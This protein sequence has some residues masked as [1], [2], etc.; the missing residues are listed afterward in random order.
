MYTHQ[1]N[2]A[3]PG[4]YLKTQSQKLVLSFLSFEIQKVISQVLIV[5]LLLLL[6]HTFG[7][8]TTQPLSRNPKFTGT[9]D[10]F[11]FSSYPALAI[12]HSTMINDHYTYLNAQTQ[13][14]PNGLGFGGQ[15]EY[16]GLFVS[17]DFIHGH[18][19]GRPSTTFGNYTLSKNE[20][21]TVDLGTLLLYE[22][23]TIS[24]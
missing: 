20:E 16:F 24:L 3:I 7:A 12:Y 4:L 15:M 11:L 19:K 6:G 18:S 2:K 9:S 13:T 17:N 5:Y 23:L 1:R 22:R 10:T 8:Y 21:F 14:L